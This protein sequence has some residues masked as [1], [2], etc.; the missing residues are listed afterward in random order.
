MTKIPWYFMLMF[1]DIIHHFF[2]IIG[3]MERVEERKIKEVV[4]GY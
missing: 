1:N 4:V 2:V 3:L